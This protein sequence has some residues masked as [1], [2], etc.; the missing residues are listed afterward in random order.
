MILTKLAVKNYGVFREQVFVLLPKS[1]EKPIILFGGKNGAGKTSLFEAVKLCLYGPAFRGERMSDQKYEKF[2]RDKINRNPDVPF[3]TEAW[4][5]LEFKHIQFGKVD[6]YSVKRYWENTGA[7]VKESMEIFKNSQLLAD[8][9]MDQWQD[10]VNELIPQGVA[11]LFFFDGEQIQNLAEDEKNNLHLKESFDSLLGLDIIERLSIDLKYLSSRL[12]RQ[13][14]EDANNNL[15]L[16]YDEQSRLKKELDAVNTEVSQ[17][18]NDIRSLKGQIQRQEELIAKEGGGYAAKRQ[19]LKIKKD[20]L[21]AQIHETENLIREM[22]AGLLPFEISAEYSEN[23]KQQLIAEDNYLQSLAAKKSLD[24]KLYEILERVSSDEFWTGLRLEENLRIKLLNRISRIIDEKVESSEITKPIIIHNL[25]GPDQQKVLGWIDEALTQVPTRIKELSENLEKL[26]RERQEIEKMLLRSPP[27]EV[28]HPYI[29]QLNK[30]HTDLGAEEQK[31]LNSEEKRKAVKF[32]IDEVVRKLFK[33]HEKQKQEELQS[34]KQELIDKTKSLLQ[35][36]LTRVREQR[37]KELQDNLLSSLS[38]LLHKKL[39]ERVVIDSKD[40]SVTLYDVYGNAI[41][42]EQ[43]S[44]GEKQ[45]YAIAMLWA[46]AKTS[47]RPLPFIIDTPL[48]R[49]DSDHRLNLVSNF[50]PYAGHQVIIFS[51]DTEID[52]EYFEELEP[53]ISRAYHLAFDKTR[54]ATTVSDGYFWKPA[55]EMAV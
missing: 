25:S 36:Y 40:F 48:G 22:C 17:I 30:L 28:L 16:L 21:E 15:T 42:K 13:S 39:F 14:T 38:H 5:S 43:L 51:T 8:I 49:L 50:F 20:V 37:L 55:K 31:L 32:K 11:K 12:R 29:Q 3:L 10:F 45:I 53:F 6:T 41:P 44:A 33:E 24:K 4:I 23:V 46:L 26:T 34:N 54:G 35:D 47:G 2:L 7:H 19:E 27:E 9:E 52:Q 1:N 18:Q